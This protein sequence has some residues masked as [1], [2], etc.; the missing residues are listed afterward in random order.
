[1]R[2]KITHLPSSPEEAEEAD[3]VEGI[4]PSELSGRGRGSR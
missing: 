2:W 1:M 3:E 4:T